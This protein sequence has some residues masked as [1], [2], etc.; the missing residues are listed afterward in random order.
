MQECSYGCKQSAKYQFKNGK[1]CCSEHWTKC[2]AMKEKLVSVNNTKYLC[3][4]CNKHIPASSWEKHR[5]S[6]KVNECLNCRAPINK[7]RKFCN[8]KCAAIYN[9]RY[10]EKLKN[11]VRG[12]NRKTKNGKCEICNEVL[13]SGHSRFCSTE[14]RNTST[15]LKIKEGKCTRAATIKKYLISKRGYVCEICG[16]SEWVGKPVG[17]ILDHIEGNSDNNVPN[18]LQLVCGNCDM[19]LPTYKGKNLG[20]GRYYRR[21]RYAE[22]K[23]Y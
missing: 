9:N 11:S 17:L 5:K 19:Q 20:K 12:P 14:C 18:N 6:C 2:P 1:W 7:S 13:K 4:K 23:S 21:I 15:E 8:S 22:G 3:H 10:S 16:I